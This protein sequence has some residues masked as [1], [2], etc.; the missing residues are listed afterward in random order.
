MSAS[1]AGEADARAVFDRL[2]G[3]LRPKLHR[4]CARMAGSVIDGEDVLQDALMKAVKAFPH[5]GPLAST[6]GW[7]FRIAHNA[8]LDHLRRRTRQDAIHTDADPDLIVDSDAVTDA[9]QSAAASLRTFMRLSVAQRSSVILMD[10]LGYSLQEMSDI[11]DATIPAVKAALH[12]GRTRLRALAQEPDDRPIPALAAPE[13]VLLAAYI[14]RF[15]ARDFDAIRDLLA[16]E[17]RLDLVSR[18]QATGRRDVATY[19][20]HYSR[21]RDWHYALGRV[22]DRLAVLVCDPADLTRVLYF[23]LLQWSDGRLAAIRDFRYARYATIDAD[24]TVLA[25]PGGL[26]SPR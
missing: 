26:H 5:A 18:T 7:L 20:G 12:R 3:E 17:V 8:A 16:D 15:N 21:L 1:I 6:E 9:R 22:E 19:V 25:K 2:L 24:M 13:Q 4:Y 11:M 10:V 14:E 23:V